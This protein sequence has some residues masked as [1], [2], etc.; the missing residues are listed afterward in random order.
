MF[1]FILVRTIN[2]NYF[3]IFNGNLSFVTIKEK[4]LTTNYFDPLVS[5]NQLLENFEFAVKNIVDII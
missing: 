5:A 1:A 4:K 2:K 3:T